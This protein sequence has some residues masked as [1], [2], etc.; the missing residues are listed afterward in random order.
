MRLSPAR[1]RA[2]DLPRAVLSRQFLPAPLAVALGSGAVWGAQRLWSEHGIRFALVSGAAIG[3]ARP[4]I[5]RAANR[6]A[7]HAASS[8][9]M[10]APADPIEVPAPAEPVEVTAPAEPVEVTVRRGVRARV[11]GWVV[12]AV[13]VSGWAVVIRPPRQNT[14]ALVVNGVLV[15]VPLIIAYLIRRALRHRAEHLSGAT[16]QPVRVVGFCDPLTRGL[17][18]QPVD[19][20]PRLAVLPAWKWR[21]DAAVGDVLTWVGPWTPDP[22]GS[23]AATRQA[24]SP[25]WVLYT[26]RRG[27]LVTSVVA[28]DPVV[29]P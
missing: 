6:A 18:L 19:G 7:A 28:F 13:V 17:V 21:L 15:A 9:T 12:V 1:F 25:L 10:A 23:A 11:T 22:V 29:T 8:P 24:P 2:A 4:A 16:V 3:L 26:G 14:A 27:Y 20:G 5:T